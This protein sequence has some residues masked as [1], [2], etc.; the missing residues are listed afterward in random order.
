MLNYLTTDCVAHLE[1]FSVL[2]CHQRVKSSLHKS[3]WPS[4]VFY[5]M[6]HV[7]ILKLTAHKLQSLQRFK[8]SVVLACINSGSLWQLDFESCCEWHCHADTAPRTDAL[9]WL[10]HH[11]WHFSPELTLIWHSS[12][13]YFLSIQKHRLWRQHQNSL[14]PIITTAFL[15]YRTS[16]ILSFLCDVQF[17]H[18]ISPTIRCVIE[19]WATLA[20]CKAVCKVPS[21]C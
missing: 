10:D 21:M 1:S 13:I 6:L 2:H 20:R 14:N 16:D 8:R 15:Y 12:I 17:G 9:K 7:C 4:R 5:G 11:L 19:H 18:W 3:L